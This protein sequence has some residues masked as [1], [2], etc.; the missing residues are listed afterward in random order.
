[1]GRGKDWNFDGKNWWLGEESEGSVRG[2]CGLGVNC[3]GN[4]ERE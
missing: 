3:D 2:E 1:M 4:R